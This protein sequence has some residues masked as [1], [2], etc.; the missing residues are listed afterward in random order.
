VAA[1]S[2]PPSLH[3]LGDCVGDELSLDAHANGWALRREAAAVGE[4]E[5]RRDRFE[6]RAPED[7]WTVELVQTPLARWRLVL[8]RSTDK[9]DVGVYLPRRVGAGG[10]LTLGDAHR[11]F[12]KGPWIYRHW[13]VTDAVGAEAARI[14]ASPSGPVWL[15]DSASSNRGDDHQ[16]QV[17][18]RGCPLPAPRPIDRPTQS[19]DPRRASNPARDL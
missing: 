8:R 17:R 18:R 13:I 11:Y 10:T 3:P 19:D 6:L 14:R 12:L 7:C 16:V 2:H 15:G 4:I 5:R 9:A 1:P